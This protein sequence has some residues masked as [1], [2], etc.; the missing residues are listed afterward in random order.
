[1]NVKIYLN[2]RVAETKMLTLTVSTFTHWI[3]GQIK[4]EAST[5]D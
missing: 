2:F 5:S 4:T 3:F 1:L